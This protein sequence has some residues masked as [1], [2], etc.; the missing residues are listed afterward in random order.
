MTDIL[1][2]FVS[3]GREITTQDIRRTLDAIANVP[4]RFETRLLIGVVLPQDS[5]ATPIERM[6]AL[7]KLMQR[8]RKAGLASFDRKKWSIGPDAWNRIQTMMSGSRT[9]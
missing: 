4:P 6:E 8:L 3:L 9:T 2:P 7:N 5:D 1:R